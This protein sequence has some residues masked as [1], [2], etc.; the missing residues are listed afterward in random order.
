MPKKGYK[1]TDEWK[2]K[3]SLLMKGRKIWDTRLH[4]NFGKHLSEETKRKI[5][6]SESGKYVS[7]ETR[8]ILS[9]SHKGKH[10][11][12][13]T[14]I[15]KGEHKSPE[16]EFTKGMISWSKGQHLSEEHK[17]K[18]GNGNKG[19]KLSSEHILKLK[20]A[21]S[22]RPSWNKGLPKETHPMFNKKHKLE[23][24]KKMSIT[25]KEL[26]KNNPDMVKR[27]AMKVKEN[28]KI[29]PNFGMKGKKQSLNAIQ[30]TKERRALQIFPIKD[31]KI[32]IKIQNY[33]MQL[34]IEFTAHH[35]IKNIEHG[36]Q[37]DIFI[38]SL[39]TILECDGDY[40]HGNP[41][42]FPKPNEMQEKQIEE[43]NIRTKELLERGY[44]VIRIWEYEI[45]IMSLDDFKKKLEITKGE[46]KCIH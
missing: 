9:I 30:R 44:R 15:K 8:E 37:C 12:P 10:Y 1:H 25:H 27:I 35:Y 14:E 3:M 17:I 18:I 2:R 46:L 13:V 45:K 16:T 38:P 29:N 43:D 24:L 42:K 23:S 4:P 5:S 39:N 26:I 34:G 32:E 22:G 7:K 21:N 11:S 41:E 28:A 31:T 20:L 36:Y 6:Q 33:L 40:W 19:K